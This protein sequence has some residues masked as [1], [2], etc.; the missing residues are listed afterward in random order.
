M[1]KT[2]A[3]LAAEARGYFKRGK[4]EAPGIGPILVHK[5]EAPEWV[6]DLSRA[7]HDDG[8]ILPDDWRF[9]FIGD[10]LDL[11]GDMGDVEDVDDI[12][13]RFREWFDGAYVYTAEQLAWLASSGGRLGYCDEA[14]EEFGFSGTTLERIAL[15]MAYEAE[16]VF[17]SVLSSLLARLDG[18][19][20]DHTEVRP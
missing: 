19:L 13:E 18:A 4:R 5:D 9:E 14:A 10:A 20:D 6:K 3:D 12:R 7:A 8:R 15:G 17:E 2:L 1:S 16:E 11:I